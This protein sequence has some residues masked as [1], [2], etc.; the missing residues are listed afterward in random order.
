MLVITR[1]LGE[2]IHVSG[3][4]GTCVVTVI[5]VEATRVRLLISRVE[6]T[7]RVPRLRSTTAEL[8]IHA[9]IDA[10]SIAAVQLA[11]VRGPKVRLGV[12]APKT[13]NVHRL[14]VIEALE[15]GGR[16]DHGDD[17]LSGS[18]ARR[19]DR[20]PPLPRD[21]RLEEPRSDA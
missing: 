16:D 9:T 15:N 11:D 20:P 3:T 13:S 21:V 8:E 19:P 10:G 2:S 12:L 4:A 1:Q 18:P 5:H 7:D 17:D 6:A 14:E